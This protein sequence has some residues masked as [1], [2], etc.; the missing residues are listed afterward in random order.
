MSHVIRSPRTD[1]VYWLGNVCTAPARTCA[2]RNRLVIAELDQ[3]KPAVRRDT[4]TTID[5]SPLGGVKEMKYSN[6]VL[7][8][9]RFSRNLIVVMS[10][11]AAVGEQA[12]PDHV[13][14]GYRYEIEA[15]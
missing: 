5:E 7:Y 9:D 13:S 15:G 8:V 6:Y 11:M 2:P 1:K 3:R 4:V 14:N 10:E 12:A